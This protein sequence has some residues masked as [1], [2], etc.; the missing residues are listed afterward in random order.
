MQQLCR[1]VHYLILFVEVAL[2]RGS[3]SKGFIAK[4]VLHVA[5]ILRSENYSIG[6]LAKQGLHASFRLPLALGLHQSR[7]VSTLQLEEEKASTL[8]PAYKV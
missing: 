5:A 8:E 1:R 6:F 3:L 7:N 4:K 2:E